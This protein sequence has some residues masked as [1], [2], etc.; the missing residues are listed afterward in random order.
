MD[1]VFSLYGLGIMAVFLS[2]ASGKYQY[3]RSSTT[4]KFPSKPASLSVRKE[5]GGTEQRSMRELIETR[6]PS[7]FKDFRSLWWLFKFVPRDSPSLL[8]IAEA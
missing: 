8:R 7:V 4:I 6:V 2:L 1:S 3:P 5:E